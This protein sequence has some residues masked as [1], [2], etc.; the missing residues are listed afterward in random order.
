MIRSHC[1]LQ[2]NPFDADSITLLSHQQEVFDILRV[3]AQQGYRNIHAAG[4]TIR[5]YEA[6]H[7]MRKGQVRWVNGK[8]VRVQVRFIGQLFG[9]II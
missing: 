6:I 4:R 1:G 5:G 8:D 7:K 2:R 3:H 9:V